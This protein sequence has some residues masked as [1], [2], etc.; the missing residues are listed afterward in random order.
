MDLSLTEDMGKKEVRLVFEG[1][2]QKKKKKKLS[3]SGYLTSV[4]QKVC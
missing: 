3:G 1:L 2:S 4:F